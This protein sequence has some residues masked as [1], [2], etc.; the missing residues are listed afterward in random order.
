MRFGVGARLAARPAV[1]KSSKVLEGALLGANFEQGAD[2]RTH[3]AAKEPGADDSER[4]RLSVV[5]KL[6]PMDRAHRMGVRPSRLGKGRE[7]SRALDLCGRLHGLNVL[8]ALTYSFAQ[9]D[10]EAAVH[11]LRRAGRADA[12]LYNRRADTLSGGQRQR[13]FEGSIIFKWFYRTWILPVF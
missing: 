6:G 12:E 2:Q 13:V 9:E 5:E 10:H 3:H 1:E 8:R 11:A 4:Q 7:V